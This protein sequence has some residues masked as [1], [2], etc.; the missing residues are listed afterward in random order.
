M[1]I[2]L[3]GANGLLGTQ[4]VKKL[5]GKGHNLHGV[6]RGPS[7]SQTGSTNYSYHDVDILDGKAIYDL[8]LSLKPEI[9]LHAAAMTQVD[10]CEE[11]KIDCWNTN[12]TAT[13]FIIDAGKENQSRIIFISTDFVFDG[14]DGPYTEED[15]PNPVNYYGSSKWAG[16]KAVEES[17]LDWAI[18]RTALVYGSRENGQRANIL[19]WLKTNLQKGERMKM[20]NDQVRTPTYVE[21]VVDGIILA[22]EKKAKGI[23]HISGKEMLTPYQ[24]AVALANHLGLDESLIEKVDGS[25]FKQVAVRPLRTVF[26]IEKARKQLG[27]E[28]RSFEEALR[29]LCG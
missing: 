28:P 29:A 3:T 19:S 22:L 11:N 24:M 15:E 1:K 25:S 7:R 23:F 10:E 12:V 14:T 13:R 17:G 4:L 16:E 21:D 2:L 8:I 20:V 27:Y 5:I 26:N 18:I 6:G 9:I